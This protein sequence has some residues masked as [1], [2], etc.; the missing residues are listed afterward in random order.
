MCNLLFAR[1]FDFGVCMLRLADT[2]SPRMRIRDARQAFLSMGVRPL[3][4][5]RAIE[6]VDALLIAGGHGRTSSSALQ[7]GI[8]RGDFT[9]DWARLMI[10]FRGSGEVLLPAIPPTPPRPQSPPSSCASR[11]SLCLLIGSRTGPCSPWRTAPSGW[12]RGGPAAARRAPFA[13]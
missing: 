4:E 9:L 12:R 5:G 6:V 1:I 8:L 10:D 7:L 3:I 2:I 11:P 13:P